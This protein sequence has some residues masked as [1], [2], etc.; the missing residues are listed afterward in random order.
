MNT[1]ARECMIEFEE[2]KSKFIG[3][4]KPV[5]TKGEAEEF[6]STIKMMHP[7][8]THN[9]SAYKVF[10]DGQEY[11][12]VDDDGEPG[13]TAGKPMGEILN[14]LEVDNLVVVATRYFGGVK[15]GAGGLVRNYAKT[16]KLAVQEAGIVEYIER[17]KYVLDFAYD[18]VNEVDS[19]I[20]SEGGEVLEKEYLDR[21][22]YRVSVEKG[23]A[24]KL[25]E[26]RDIVIFEI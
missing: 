13:G 4:V 14:L 8:A 19:V 23:T 12:K 5:S 24:E 11:F 9:C 22:T 10:D 26:I 21:V 18:R 17:K 1:I 16:A 2:K 25:R 3:Y 20:S 15:L 6:I 7:S